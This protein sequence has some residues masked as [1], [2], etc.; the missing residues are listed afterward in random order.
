MLGSP[1][2][3]GTLQG[4]DRTLYGGHG[5]PIPGLEGQQAAGAGPLVRG[6]AGTWE[7]GGNPHLTG[8]LAGWTG[9]PCPPGEQIG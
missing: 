6:Q 9:A 1:K 8:K 3:M 7:Q 5:A 4:E 2:R